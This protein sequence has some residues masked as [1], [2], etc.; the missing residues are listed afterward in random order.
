MV[1]NSFKIL[2][3]AI[4]CHYS[5]V[6]RFVTNLKR[7]N[8]NV[9]I[10]LFTAQKREQLA[11][12]LVGSLSEIIFRK[13]SDSKGR[14]GSIK[15]VW[16]L[17][18]QFRMLSKKRKFDIVNVHFPILLYA[19][20]MPFVKR[21][22]KKVVASPWG[23]DILRVNGWRF[24]LLCKWVIGKCD[25][26]TVA[27]TSKMGAKINTILKKPEHFFYPLEWG[28]ETIDYICDTDKK[29][30][31]KEAKEKLGISDCYVIT[32]GYNAF[33]AQRHERIIEAIA[34]VREKLP[35]NLMLLFPVT[36]GFDDRKEYVNTLR[37]KCK[38]LGM[39]TLFFE[40][41][42][43]MPQLY[44]LRMATDMLIHIQPTDVGASSIQEYILCRKKIIH[45]TWISYPH[46][47][48]FK[49]LFYY[50]V[51]ELSELGDVIVSTFLSE[52]IDFSQELMEDLR[53]RGWKAKMKLWNDFFIK[54][55]NHTL[56]M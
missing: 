12:E 36:Y 54:I 15:N 30:T 43:S 50:P 51:S 53:G 24:K 35:S 52:S 11:P 14:L 22:A 40:E 46:L 1:N 7:T 55:S 2:I 21:M 32:C 13:K 34:E 4:G 3:L 49:P 6:T 16:T 41:Y 39:K 25:Y 56:S 27:E 20:I 5:H 42:L 48:K 17:V 44:I 18:N 26:V 47:E 31:T 45:G 38:S 37:E 8:P 23:S 33:P 10:T 19:P 29:I 28:A 9:E